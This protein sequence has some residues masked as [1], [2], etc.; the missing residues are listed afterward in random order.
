MSLILGLHLGHDASVAI[1]RDGVPLFCLSEE[2]LAREKMYYGFPFR[3]LDVA[4]K[5]INK[6]P[7]EIDFLA[8]DTTE[9]AG[10]IGPEEMKRRFSRQTSKG[11]ARK[12]ELAKEVV[13]GLLGSRSIASQKAREREAKGILYQNLREYGFDTSRLKI[14]PHHLCHAASAFWPSPFEEAMFV[15]SDGRGDGLSASLGF[16]RDNLLETRIRIRDVDSIGQLYAAVTF[17]LGYKPNRHE[18]KITGLAAFGDSQK[19]GPELLQNVTWNADGSYTFQVPSEFRLSSV[20][21]FDHFVKRLPLSLK[22]RVILHSRNDLNT[23]MY[24]TNWF[25]LLA[26]LESV[27]GNAKH[28]DVAAGVQF[29]VE[30]V[31]TKF[32]KSNLPDRPIPIVLAGGVFSNVRINQKIRE[33]EG[34]SDIF[35]QPAMADEGLS[36]GAALLAYVEIDPH[37]SEVLSQRPRPTNIAHTY[38]GP[39]YSRDEIKAACIDEEIEFAEI[40]D[41]EQY[42]A[43]LIHAGA[44]VGYFHG[45]IEYGPRALGHRSIILRPTDKTVNETLNKRFRRTEFMPFAPSMINERAGEYLLN[46]T[47]G[48]IVSEFMTATYDIHPERQEEIQAV[49]HIDGTARPQV[50]FEHK[51]P[52]YHRIIKEYF[53][54]SGIPVVVNTSF[55]MHEEPIVCTPEDA[56]RAFKVDCVDVLVM[57]NIVV[58]S[59]E[60]W[61]DEDC[62]I[63]FTKSEEIVCA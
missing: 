18:G 44:V 42:I 27:A 48:Q 23:L 54:L 20:E 5:H 57:E 60:K 3:S 51:D 50:V 36:L 40:D 55:N 32:V 59:V 34:V 45:R 53:K 8:L 35:V 19:L 41:I 14:Y 29:F 28:E 17:F 43:R 13:T 33:L 58:G 24:N 6:R 4:F 7:E 16:A 11:V 63:G 37:A 31:C 25:G 61:L 10:L 46:Y 56:I 26:Y 15:T 39:E 62:A 9:L 47:P 1:V 2:R 30:E 12:L 52:E 49:V 38:L 21:E 22:E